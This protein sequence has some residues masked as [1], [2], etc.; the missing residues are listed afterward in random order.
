MILSHTVKHHSSLD[1]QLFVMTR[2]FVK[3]FFKSYQSL[4]SSVTSDSIIYSE[5]SSCILKYLKINFVWKHHQ[6][7]SHFQT[8]NDLLKASILWDIKNVNQLQHWVK[9]D[10][11]IFL[12]DLN[13]LW[14]QRDLN[15]KACDLFDK[16]S[17]EQIWKTRFE[18][19]DWAKNDQ[20]NWIRCFRTNWLKHNINCKWLKMSLHRL[21]L[22]SHSASDLRSFRIHLC[23]LMKK[24]LSEMIDKKRFVTS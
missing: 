1:H 24:N 9:Q 21:L 4:Y 13:S 18:E 3:N 22:F 5:L 11:E 23:L 12:A 16:I 14:T 2:S 15:V 19:I 8:F 6:S 7:L 10:L 17:S 20:I